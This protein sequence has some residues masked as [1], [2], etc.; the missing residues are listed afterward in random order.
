[1]CQ[2]VYW[3]SATLV[4]CIIGVISNQGSS[5]YLLLPIKKKYLIEESAQQL[6]GIENK[7]WPNKLINIGHLCLLVIL[8][9]FFKSRSS[10]CYL[11][12]NYNNTNILKSILD[13]FYGFKK[14]KYILHT[15]I[16]SGSKV[17]E[18]K[19]VSIVSVIIAQRSKH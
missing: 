17:V 19:L 18:S 2:S 13:F 3:S 16:K 12:K 15:Y 10:L 9:H 4:A 8:W 1:M 7:M 5:G 14:P 6:L 11:Y